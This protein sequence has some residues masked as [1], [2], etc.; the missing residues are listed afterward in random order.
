MTES[1]YDRIATANQISTVALGII[2]RINHL[3]TSIQLY[4]LYVT[5]YNLR[6]YKLI[7]YT[8]CKRYAAASFNRKQQQLLSLLKYNQW[9]SSF[10]E[11]M[12]LNRKIRTSIK[13]SKFIRYASQNISTFYRKNTL[14]E[15]NNLCP[16]RC[17]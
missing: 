5:Q 7:E 16:F 3:S 15:I 13:Q 12:S 11:C 4:I 17:T 1:S 14:K 10:Y 9:E 8:L 2:T 6:Y